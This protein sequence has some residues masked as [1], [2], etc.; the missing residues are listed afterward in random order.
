[1]TGKAHTMTWDAYNRRKDALRE[2]LT[3]A[4]RQRDLTLTDLLDAV[5]PG[6]V[7]FD[8]E[9]EVLYDLQ[10]LWFQR[11]SGHLER[12][13]SEARENPELVAVTAWIN[14]A[15]E[16]PR[17]R[18]LLDSHRDVPQLQ[19]AFAKELAYLATSAGVPSY[20]VD[21]AD[22]GQRIQDAARA[23][24]VVPQPAGI[25]EPSRAGLIAR[26]RNAIAA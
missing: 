14:A 9:V 26:L 24:V 15:A 12:V 16:L 4:D 18:A 10:M 11:L 5:D 6:R 8:S 25:S 19:K 17:V 20:R 13:I 1:M 22:H 2:M 7:A 3:L 21:L 23:S